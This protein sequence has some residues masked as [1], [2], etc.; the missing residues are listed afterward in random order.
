[1]KKTLR[2]QR[3]DPATHRPLDYTNHSDD[4]GGDTETAECDEDSDTVLHD[5]MAIEN[6]S[7]SVDLEEEPVKVGKDELSVLPSSPSVVSE[8][9]GERESTDEESE[10]SSS[11]CTNK[12]FF[13]QELLRTESPARVVVDFEATEVLEIA[14]SG[15]SVND[16]NAYVNYCSPMSLDA[17]NEGSTSFLEEEASWEGFQA[18]V[19]HTQ[20]EQ[21]LDLHAQEAGGDYSGVIPDSSFPHSDISVV[22][23]MDGNIGQYSYPFWNFGSAH[24]LASHSSQELHRQAAIL[25]QV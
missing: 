4:S 14:R 12:S 6:C 9:Q 15:S 25:D 13:G 21:S 11:T 10:K 20:V 1:M 2:N 19:S 23:S 7:E 8:L 5:A 22:R 17:S 3:L 24:L 18:L 16:V